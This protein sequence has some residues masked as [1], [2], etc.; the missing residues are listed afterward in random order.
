[1]LRIEAGIPAPGHEL[2]EQWNPLEAELRSAISFTKGCYTGQEVVAR[3]NTYKKVQ[4]TL[5]GL[6]L[7]GDEIPPPG[8]RL[9][10]A[11][12]EAGLVTSAAFSPALGAP[13]AL[14]YVALETS[15]PGTAVEVELEPGGRTAAATVLVLPLV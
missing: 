14:A 3:L 6:R 12:A 10:A 9:L 2:T 4:R 5:R 13:I 1:M 7:A 15:A 11:G 8:S